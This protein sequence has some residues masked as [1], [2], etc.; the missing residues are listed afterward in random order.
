MLHFVIDSVVAAA[1]VIALAVVYHLDKGG[2]KDETK[3]DVKVKVVVKEETPPVEVKPLRL[4]VTRGPALY[5]DMGRLLDKLGSGHKYTTISLEDLEDSKKVESYDIIFITCSPVP[6]SW[7]ILDPDKKPGARENTLTGKWNPE[8]AKRLQASLRG[9]VERGGTIYASDWQFNIVAQ[10]F[11]ELIDHATAQGGVGSKED[12]TA[13]VVDEGLRERIGSQLN[14]RFDQDG[15]FPAALRGPNA[16]VYLEGDYHLRDGRAVMV[17]LLVKIPVHQGTLIFTSFHNEKQ[18]SDKELELLRYLVF[19]TVTAQAEAKVTKTM[20]EGGF[21]PRKQN[22]LSADPGNPSFTQTYQSKKAGPV[23]FALG[24]ADKGARL[25]IE[26]TAPNGEQ[27]EKTGT[28]G[29]TVDGPDAQPGEWKYTVTAEKVPHE[30][31]PF[32]VT[33]GE[34]EK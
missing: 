16:K 23:Q 30:N 18:N 31:F 6:P 11:P 22:L 29:F 2:A 19:T 3:D 1:L 33:V 4:A 21:S 15:W 8:A 10:V 7:I 17:P 24:F 32:T 12:V 34:K 14:L 26:I 20:V 27:V 28:S 13:K 9:F 5:D 25:K